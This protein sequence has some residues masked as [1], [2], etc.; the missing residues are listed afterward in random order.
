M[1][2]ASLHFESETCQRAVPGFKTAS[3]NGEQVPLAKQEFFQSLSARFSKRC[4]DGGLI[5]VFWYLC[6]ALPRYIDLTYKQIF[7]Y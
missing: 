2:D 1:N 7:K 4:G 6:S 5:E 3:Q